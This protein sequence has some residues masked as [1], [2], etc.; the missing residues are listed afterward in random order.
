MHD[1][2]GTAFQHTFSDVKSKGSFKESHKK[3]GSSLIAGIVGLPAVAAGA[4]FLFE[5]RQ[6]QKL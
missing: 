2:K 1:K 3:K 6:K 5:V 4:A